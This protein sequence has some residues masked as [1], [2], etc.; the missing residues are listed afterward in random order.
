MQ[1]TLGIRCEIFG[2]LGE[3]EKASWAVCL[4]RWEN[5]APEVMRA[6]GVMV[7]SSLMSRCCCVSFEFFHFDSQV[8]SIDVAMW[9]SCLIPENCA[10]RAT[11]SPTTRARVRSRNRVNLRFVYKCISK[12]I[13][14]IWKWLPTVERFLVTKLNVLTPRL[15]L[16]LA[17]W[18]K[19]MRTST[20]KT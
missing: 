1:V 18:P 9:F 15:P 8:V 6:Y 7:V 20:P 16:H 11:F 2:L 12:K 10:P 3:L 5:F 17:H 14:L 4:F 19:F 13:R